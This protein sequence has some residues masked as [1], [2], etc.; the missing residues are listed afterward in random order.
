MRFERAGVPPGQPVAPRVTL[1]VIPMRRIRGLPWPQAGNAGACW[2]SAL[3]G[4]L[5]VVPLLGR[6][7]LLPVRGFDPDELQHLH[8]AWCIAQ[9]QLPYRDY[10]DH[11][12]PWLH[13]LLAPLFLLL[14]PELDFS[15]ATASLVIAR[16]FMWAF[17]VGL[18]VSTFVLGRRWAGRAP[19]GLGTLFLSN[20]V[21]FL[22]K[23]LEVRPDV[24]A[25]ALFL[26]GL[27]AVQRYG[28]SGREGRPRGLFVAGLLFGSAAMFTPK[29]VFGLF[30]VYAVLALG[31]APRRALCR[32]GCLSLGLAL[33]PLVTAS[34]WAA[35]G[36]L[37][38][39][40]HCNVWVPLQWQRGSGPGEYVG[41]LLRQDPVHVLGLWALVVGCVGLV[42]GRREDALLTL[43]LVGFLVGLFWIPEIARQYFVLFLPLLALLSG[44]ALLLLVGR[45]PWGRT[46]P[47]ALLPAALVLGLTA[48]SL[49]QQWASFRWSN[50]A[51]LQR[52]QFV[53]R[54]SGPHETVLDG[55]SGLGVFRPHAHRYYYQLGK[56]RSTWAPGE[57]QRLLRGLRSGQVFPRFVV[58]DEYVQT[59]SEA[60]SEFLARHYVD[61]GLP[62]LRA[63][64]FDNGLGRWLDTGPRRLGGAAGLGQPHV[65]LADGW[66]PPRAADGRSPGVRATAAASELLVPIAEPRD[67]KAAIRAR[68]E[69]GPTSLTLSVN[70]RVVGQA[71]VAFGWA[72]HE[73]HVAAAAL[74]PGLNAF[75][76]TWS[77]APGRQGAP[78]V[79]SL[80]LGAL[81]GGARGTPATDPG[82]EPAPRTTRGSSSP[83]GRGRAR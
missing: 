76:L 52:L 25:A 68:S 48:H 19:A 62:P 66:E 44:R 33:P 34:Y 70:G 8:G 46:L 1:R 3:F 74:R 72:D 73:L 15:H 16:A 83:P 53:L 37:G 71:I 81:G 79:A 56:I 22:A 80:A 13:V 78:V 65:L 82:G 58:W 12:T 10:F 61:V 49:A 63:R 77:P 17:T 60:V 26:T 5:L 67:C 42:R 30:G 40:L 36:A 54:N 4:A 31:V 18:L 32:L 41:E 9:G 43:P 64:L 24:P 50:R 2:V 20:T 28:A 27:L 51:F 59:T 11:H 55:F 14:R 57:R 29:V 35:R 47:A 23:T 38:E 6:L 45:I 69:A 75:R 39:F 21:M 7:W